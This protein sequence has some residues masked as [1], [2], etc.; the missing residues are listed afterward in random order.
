M[1][2]KLYIF[3]CCSSLRTYEWRHLSCWHDAFWHTFKTWD[4]IK[5]WSTNKKRKKTRN[6]FHRQQTKDSLS[7]TSEI[8]ETADESMTAPLSM[9][10]STQLY[11]NA[12]WKNHGCQPSLITPTI[13]FAYSYCSAL[14]G[15]NDRRCCCGC[16]AVTPYPLR[17]HQHHHNRRHHLPVGICWSR[18]SPWLER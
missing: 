2:T 7:S 17:Q 13:W 1:Y 10:F 16:R 11:G 12:R 9:H 4:N 8:W 14:S 5:N 6:I 15:M 3:Y 18:P